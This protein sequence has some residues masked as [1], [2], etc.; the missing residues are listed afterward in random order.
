MNKYFFNV[1]DNK[2]TTADGKFSA[3]EKSNPQSTLGETQDTNIQFQKDSTLANYTTFLAGTTARFLVDL[4]YKN[5]GVPIPLGSTG[6]SLSSGVEYKLLLSQKPDVVTFDDISASEGTVGALSAGEWGYITGTTEIVVRLADDT[7]PSTKAD[8][9]ILVTYTNAL[10]TPLFIEASSDVFNL[11]NSWLDDDGVTFRNPD[12]TQGE[13]SFTLNSN[14]VNFF[15]RLGGAT[16]QDC[17]AEIQFFEPS[18]SI[19]FMK[20]KFSYTCTNRLLTSGENPLE[21]VGV[22]VFT[23]AESDARYLNRDFSLLDTKATIVDD[24]TIAGNDSEDSGNPIVLTFT[25]LKTYFQAGLNFLSKTFSDYSAKTTLVGADTIAINDSAASFAPKNASLTNLLAYVSSELGAIVVLQGDWNANTN[26]PDITGT[27]TTGYAWRVS[28]AGTTDLDGITDWRIGDLA[29][30]TATGWLKIDNE[31][32][33]AVWGNIVGT[34]SDQDDVAEM[35]NNGL[36]APSANAT[37]TWTAGTRTV[38][39]VPAASDFKFNID[40][41]QYTKTTSQSVVIPDTSGLHYCYFDNSG[42]LVTSMTFWD[43]LVT[44]P[45]SAIYWNATTGLGF[46]LFEAHTSKFSALHHLEHHLTE[47]TQYEDGLIPIGYTINTASDASVSYTAPSG[48]IWD[49]DLRSAITGQLINDYTIFYRTGLEVNNEWS[50]DIGSTL[51]VKHTAGVADWNENNAGT[52]QQTSIATLKYI[53]YFEIAIPV[54]DGDFQKIII[55]GTIQHDS[56]LDAEGSNFIA[57]IPDWANA[58]TEF[59]PISQF[60]YRYKS[61]DGGT[62]NVRLMLVQNIAQTNVKITSSATTNTDVNA[63]HVNVAGE[64]TGLTEQATPS[65]EWL[66]AED[67]TTGNKVKIDVD[68]ISGGGGTGDMLVATYDPA[69]IGEQLTGLTAAQTLTNK[70]L[71]SPIVTGSI[72]TPIIRPASDSATAIKFQDVAGA[73]DVVSIDTTSAAGSTG[74]KITSVGNQVVSLNNAIGEYSLNGFT[75]TTPSSFFF[76]SA[77]NLTFTAASSFVDF[78]VGATKYVRCSGNGVGVYGITT[79]TARLHLPAGTATANTAPLKFESGTNLT[80]PENGAIEYDGTNL[81]FT[82]STNTRK[83]ISTGAGGITV[84]EQ[85]LTAGTQ[86]AI[87]LGAIA[88]RQ[89]YLIKFHIYGEGILFSDYTVKFWHDGTNAYFSS[90]IG[91]ESTTPLTYFD[92]DTGIDTDINATNLRML[93]TLTGTSTGDDLTIEYEVI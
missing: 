71:A 47:G 46:E 55:Q 74:V 39:I 28:V 9:F 20:A 41:T 8:D 2:L 45:V 14:T 91:N 27:T 61:G 49:E 15:N 78:T 10:A 86:N 88:N 29:V 6:W 50:W 92:V 34:I 62:S 48:H 90:P 52:W 60:I 5:P 75:F 36:I 44:S 77:G 37:I 22:D 24:D 19:F 70:T 7:D 76:N 64:I 59:R 66:I 18:T 54:I 4:D 65:G 43:L 32:I 30:K 85:T 38:A 17:F 35:L 89:S 84:E 16:K 58:L 68:N 69:G 83:T 42:T 72:T 11:A 23:K 87:I 26:T 33:S 63:V 56:L 40:G 67:P 80:T 93:F 53:N 79:P 31:D 82:D 13:V 1:A 3:N 81:Y 12:I 57:E 21:L 73:N 51:P 25:K